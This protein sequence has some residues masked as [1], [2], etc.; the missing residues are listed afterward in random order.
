MRACGMPSRRHLETACVLTS[1]N[2]ATTDVPPSR[3][4]ISECAVDSMARIV[5]MV[6]L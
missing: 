4:M 3:S 2:D 6:A 1:H 5:T